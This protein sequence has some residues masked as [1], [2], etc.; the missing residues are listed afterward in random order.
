MHQS[1]P[2]SE[3]IE[4]KPAMF[5]LLGLIL[6]IA[7]MIALAYW[8]NVFRSNQVIN[9]YTTET[10]ELVK[11]N[12]QL[13]RDFFTQTFAECEQK[14]KEYN[15]TVAATNQSSDIICPSAQEKL[16]EMKVESLKDSSAI[17]YVTFGNDGYRLI[18]A[19]GKYSGPRQIMFDD[20]SN[21]TYNHFGYDDL[22]RSQI[23]EYF[24]SGKDINRWQQFLN[25]ID[26][27]QVLVPIEIDDQVVGYIFRGVV[28]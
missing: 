10:Q 14:L 25:Y 5:V 1:T 17:G 21:Y 12:Q 27:K 3:K 6:L 24:K 7:I 2:S 16:G 22:N 19:S 13:T 4:F 18:E 11:R 28:Q 26:V 23:E 9:S 20:Y 8:Y 15:Q